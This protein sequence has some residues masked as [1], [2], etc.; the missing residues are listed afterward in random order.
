[1]K[2]T[3]KRYLFH[4][5]DPRGLPRAR[6]ISSHS[7]KLTFVM[8]SRIFS[9]KCF[10]KEQSFHLRICIDQD[11][12][13]TIDD[14][15]ENIESTSDI[16][17]SFQF[18]FERLVDQKTCDDNDEIVPEIIPLK[19]L[20]SIKTKRDSSESSDVEL[21]YIDIS[22][23]YLWRVKRIQLTMDSTVADQLIVVLP[24]F[25]G[26][27]KHR[28]RHLLV[29]LNPQCGKSKE[30]ISLKTPSNPSHLDDG[31]SV[32]EKDVSPLFKEANIDVETISTE[33]ANHAHDYILEQSLDSYDG[34]ICVGGDGMFS[35]LCH[36][37]LLKTTQQAGLDI[38][39]PNI[40]L[41]RPNLRI[42]VIPSGSTDAVVFGTTGH[43][44]PIT[45]AL[46]IITGES[47]LIDIATVRI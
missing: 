43:N 16:L 10:I 1:M 6:S 40:D 30:T 28:P 7:I 29:F 19:K 3:I 44:D 17:N 41:K 26:K 37:L 15:L 11:F 46:Q 36:S 45:S 5:I 31:C 8:S 25:L 2:I 34:L 32:Y 38:D 23:I 18:Q 14:L 42:G 24:Q 47:L 27:L 35:E 39:D 12:V 4:W 22:E 21:S 9:T 20:F 13:S 33:R